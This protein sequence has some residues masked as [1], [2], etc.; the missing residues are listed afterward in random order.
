[1]FPG[2]EDCALKIVSSKG[3]R[4]AKDQPFDKYRSPRAVYTID[5]YTLYDTMVYHI[6]YVSFNVEYI[7]YQH[8]CV[9]IY[10]YIPYPLYY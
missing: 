4:Q 6:L 3:L 8:L 7:E 5:I 1:M 10:I 9:F 2:L